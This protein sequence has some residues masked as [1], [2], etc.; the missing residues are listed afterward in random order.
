MGF[1]AAL[2]SALTKYFSF[3]GRARRSEFWWFTLFYYGLILGAGMLGNMLSGNSGSLVGPFVAVVLFG[4]FLPSVS[5]W[6]RRLHD[7]GYS[8][9]NLL[10]A[11]LPLLGGLIL[12]T[13]SFE[14]GIHGP[15]KYGPDPKNRPS[16]DY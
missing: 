14:D 5:V 15:N 4:L 12:L 2:K 8:G 16:I 7:A 13:F 10:I 9:W 3:N 1:G 6:V 11:L